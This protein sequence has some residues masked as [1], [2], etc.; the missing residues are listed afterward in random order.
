MR[1]PLLIA[2]AA[3][4]LAACKPAAPPTPADN[5]LIE[6]PAAAMAAAATLA[7]VETHIGDL[8]LR[9]PRVLE[10]PMAGAT[11]VAFLV[12]ANLGDQD[13]RLLSASSPVADRVEI[14]EM[15][16]ADGVMRMRALGDGLAIPV[17]SAVELAPGGTHLML[18]GVHEPLVAGGTVKVE[19]RFEKAG[20]ATV[21][22]PVQARQPAP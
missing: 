3:T 22:M 14:H 10:T 12:I 6:K 13:D 2:L 19:L 15:S 18:I 7:S 4:L 16:M 17:G 1:K 8:Q 5:P 21:A 9:L 20:T 11:G